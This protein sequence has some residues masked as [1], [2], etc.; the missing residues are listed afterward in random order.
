[1]QAH[2]VKKTQHILKQHRHVPLK[3]YDMMAEVRIKYYL[4]KYLIHN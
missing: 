4:T 3:L 1:M 2:S